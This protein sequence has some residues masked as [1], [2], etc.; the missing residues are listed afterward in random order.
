MHQALPRCPTCGGVL[1]RDPEA[2]GWA[3]CMLCGREVQT[4]ASQAI[5][6]AELDT[7]GRLLQADVVL[8]DPGH[9]NLAAPER[10]GDEQQSPQAHQ[11]AVWVPPWHL[12]G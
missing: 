3:T 9:R 5:P 1:F 7:L 12:A 2:P 6:P 4:V 10:P 11:P 8:T